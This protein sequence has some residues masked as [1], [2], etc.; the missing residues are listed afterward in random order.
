MKRIHLST[1]AVLSALLPFAGAAAATETVLYS[2]K[3]GTDGTYPPAGLM[4]D[5]SGA[6]YGT[7][8]YG[9]TAN[10]GTVF[11]L[12]RPAAGGRHWTETVLHSFTGGAD[13][14]VGGTLLKDN[15]GALY[16]M[17]QEGGT[18]NQGTVFKLTPPAA[19]QTAWTEIVLYR[20][21]GGRD[22]R[23]PLGDLIAKHGVLY[24]MTNGGGTANTGTV[25]KLRPPAAG[26]TAWTERVLYRFT[27]GTDGTRPQAGLLA[28]AGLLANKSGFLFGT[29]YQ[30]GVSN[31]GTVFKVV[32]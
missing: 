4:M 26:Q 14:A 13:G 9:G 27:G 15:A 1:I 22:G 17:T 28:T 23:Y 29:T 12:T 32:P 21:K 18:G 8:V 10:A 24:G 31:K 16:G 2:F 30:G 19:G 5:S 11:K 7:T 3:G 25:F 20:F 6:L